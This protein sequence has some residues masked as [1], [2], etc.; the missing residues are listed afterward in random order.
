MAAAQRSVCSA[1]HQHPGKTAWKSSL[2]HLRG[3]SE[4]GK[5]ETMPCNSSSARFLISSWN[6][7]QFVR[8]RWLGRDWGAQI[9]C[10]ASPI[11]KNA[12]RITTCSAEWGGH[13]NSANHKRAAKGRAK[14]GRGENK[15][16]QSC[17]KSLFK[18]H[19]YKISTEIPE[20]FWKH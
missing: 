14:L 20:V 2:I 13:S 11:Y 8:N 1:W 10:K 12:P 4:T 9:H 17:N 15:Q 5:A 6:L 7:C 16:D 3:S 18:A 19:S